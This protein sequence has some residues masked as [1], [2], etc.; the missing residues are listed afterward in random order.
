MLLSTREDGAL[1]IKI[2]LVG[3]LA[4]GGCSDGGEI[5][6]NGGE[7]SMSGGGEM[8]G[9]QMAE[10]EVVQAMAQRCRVRQEL[11]LVDFSGLGAA[12]CAVWS[13]GLLGSHDGKHAHFELFHRNESVMDVDHEL[14]GEDGTG[15]GLWAVVENN[16]WRLYAHVHG[17]GAL[18]LDLGALLRLVLFF[19]MLVMLVAVE[20]IHDERLLGL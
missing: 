15:R 14:P 10:G 6:V 9:Q 19:G 4:R 12:V 7:A 8:A 18:G 1:D 17:S 5:V 2:A 16:G 11:P 20:D 3:D 13:H